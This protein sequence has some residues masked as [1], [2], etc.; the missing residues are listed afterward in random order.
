[1]FVAQVIFFR[2]KDCHIQA[3]LLYFWLVVQIVIFYVMVAYGIALWGAYI[4]WEAEKEEK[5]TQKAV[6]KYMKEMLKKQSTIQ[7]IE[8]EHKK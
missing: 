4:C 8:Q 1:M 5:E 7:A 2:S 6:K 3:P